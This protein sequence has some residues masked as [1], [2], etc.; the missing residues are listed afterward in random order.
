M[1]NILLASILLCTSC[2]SASMED[3]I[4]NK[5]TID[6]TSIE[7][8]IQPLPDVMLSG[9]ITANKNFSVSK[10]L[11]KFDDNNLG[12]TYWVAII[13]DTIHVD[14]NFSN[15][16]DIKLDLF[17]D[18]KFINIISHHLTT[19]EKAGNTLS[20]V[21]NSDTTLEKEI[22]TSNITTLSVSVTGT[23]DFNQLPKIIENSLTMHVNVDINKKL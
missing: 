20:L 16:D 17:S 21:V 2:I 3:D 9:T 13:N 19:E 4:T 5:I 23:L 22:L 7:N 1:K 15:I 11:N 6:L 12:F 10:Q 8:K 14:T 18:N